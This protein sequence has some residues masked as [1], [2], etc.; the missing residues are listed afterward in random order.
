M[1]IWGEKT[2]ERNTTKVHEVKQK[3]E[4]EEE[5]KKKAKKKRRKL[6]RREEKKKQSNSACLKKKNEKGKQN[7]D[8]QNYLLK[9]SVKDSDLLST[10]NERETIKTKNRDL[11]DRNTK[12][13]NKESKV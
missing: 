11:W 8:F 9:H 3:E 7:G 12:M 13:N 10:V 6:K 2:Y 5:K 4:E 1:I